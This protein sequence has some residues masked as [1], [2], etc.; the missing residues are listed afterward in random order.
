MVVVDLPP[1][2]L[3]GRVLSKGYRADRSQRRDA[4]PSARACAS[5]VATA[6]RCRQ[7]ALPCNAGWP[8][9]RRW[10]GPLSGVSDIGREHQ[11]ILWWCWRYAGAWR[12]V[13]AWW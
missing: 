10:A 4:R 13:A 5:A 2:A 12:S 7:S 8:R 9:P 1:C 6:A 3:S 11:P